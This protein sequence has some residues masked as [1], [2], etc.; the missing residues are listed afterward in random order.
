MKPFKRSPVPPASI[1]KFKWSSCLQ[2]NPD[3]FSKEAADWSP[4]GGNNYRFNI[5]L[6]DAATLALFTQAL[7][8]QSLAHHSQPSPAT[9][10]AEPS[11]LLR[12]GNEAS[13]LAAS[14]CEVRELDA[15]QD[16][17]DGPKSI[18]SRAAQT[19]SIASTEQELIRGKTTGRNE[20]V[21]SRSVLPEEPATKGS[22]IRQDMRSQH[23]EDLRS[24]L[25]KMLKINPTPVKP[26]DTCNLRQTRPAPDEL[27]ELCLRDSEGSKSVQAH[28]ESLTTSD[29][30]SVRLTF[31]QRLPALLSN[32]PGTYTLV[33]FIK[34]DKE[35]FAFCESFCSINMEKLQQNKCAVKLMHAVAEESQKFSAAY[36][37]AFRERY[38]NSEQTADHYLLLNKVIPRIA[39]ESDL[40]FLLESMEASFS[41]IEAVLRS[42]TLRVIPALLERLS[43]R[44]AERVIATV[45]PFVDS[46]VD[47]KLGLYTILSL[48]KTKFQD[49]SHAVCSVLLARPLFMFTRKQRMTILAKMLASNDEFPIKFFDELIARLMSCRD[50]QELKYIFHYEDSTCLLLN[51]LIKLEN[52][53]LAV[54]FHNDYF[55]PMF[56]N[57]SVVR[58]PIFRG[59]QRELA[60]ISDLSSCMQDT[61]KH[62][63]SGRQ[64]SHL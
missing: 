62:G 29:L 42:Q 34:I 5:R 15:K 60:I 19:T 26:T 58:G 3:S 20:S 61:G 2:S 40:D 28:I 25:F 39:E 45:L 10:S 52:P 17:S 18:G 48:L 14:S 30:A 46:L 35:F 64:S 12:R 27:V 36:L 49:S 51:V 13:D 54:T 41:T 44:K 53:S 47:D 11:W 7:K 32:L 21:P 37:K 23:N 4:N 22:P 43:A 59:F 9:V 50:L 33:F 56:A 1:V 8:A 24:K 63:S 16:Q 55:K 38:T 31:Q 57:Q 6:P